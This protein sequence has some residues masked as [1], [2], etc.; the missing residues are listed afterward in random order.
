MG[1]LPRHEDS[2]QCGPAVQEAAVVNG[3]GAWHGM[4]VELLLHWGHRL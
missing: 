2:S 1:Q 4:G 3:G